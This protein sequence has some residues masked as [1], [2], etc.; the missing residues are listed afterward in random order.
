LAFGFGGK[1]RFSNWGSSSDY[2]FRCFILYLG[3]NHV[4]DWGNLFLLNMVLS[5]MLLMLLVFLMVVFFLVFKI[6]ALFKVSFLSLLIKHVFS[7]H[8]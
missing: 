2:W 4:I 8:V 3:H 7:D 5:M 1:E 6:G